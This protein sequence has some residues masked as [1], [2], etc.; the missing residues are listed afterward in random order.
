MHND[1]VEIGNVVEIEELGILA[2]V[3]NLSLSEVKLIEL[4]LEHT[5]IMRPSKFRELK[6]ENLSLGVTGKK[7]KVRQYVEADISYNNTKEEVEAL[8]F[9]ARE[10]MVDSIAVDSIERKYFPMEANVNVELIEF[11]DDAVKYRFFYEINSP[12]YI[13]KT[14]YL[15]NIYLQKAQKKYGIDFSTPKLLELSKTD[16]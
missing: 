2:W 7:Q 4:S 14:R 8:F 10:E 3:K 5:I 9:Y 15:L 13:L 12:F 11:G 1:Q 6:V 16:I